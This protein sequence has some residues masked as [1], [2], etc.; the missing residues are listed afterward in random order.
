[1]A[2]DARQIAAGV[3]DLAFA[4]SR[5]SIEQVADALNLER[6][7]R[8]IRCWR[9]EKHEHG[10]RTPSVGIDRRRNR[11]KCFRCDAKQLS[12]VDLV[13]SVLGLDTYRALLWLDEHFEISR[14]QPEAR[15]KRPDTPLRVGVSGSCFELAVYS[16]LFAEMNAAEVRLLL[17]LDVFTDRLT[18]VAFLSYRGL[19]RYAGIGSDATLCRSLR[20]LKNLGAVE[21]I[22]G[23]GGDGLPTC[24]GYRLTLGD[25]SFV[26]FANDCLASFR[27]EIETERQL[28]AQSRRQRVLTLH[29]ARREAKHV[30][31]GDTSTSLVKEATDKPLHSQCSGELVE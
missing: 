6:H 21:I 31:T 17:V 25:A 24:N 15:R 27:R 12:T 28:R 23:R 5:I 20:R 14:I 1:V 4:K 3:P 2:A 10:D 30:F 7:G 9:P 13:Q 29:Q 22:R 26:A 11:A 16:G 18:G 19:R 8:Q